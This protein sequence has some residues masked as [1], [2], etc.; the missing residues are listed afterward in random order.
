MADEHGVY[1][2][3][4]STDRMVLG[5][6]GQ[7]SELELDNSI[8]RMVEARWNKARRGEMMT[9]PPAG[10]E[11]DDLGQLAITSDEADR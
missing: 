1:D 3:S 7:M 4:V 8:R 6:R 5:L 10:Y 11:V 9:I 2:L